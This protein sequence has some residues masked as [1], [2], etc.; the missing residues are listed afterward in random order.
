MKMTAD[1]R[2]MTIAYAD[3]LNIQEL[4]QH[5]LRIEADDLLRP[6]ARKA[7][8]LAAHCLDQV[9]TDVGLYVSAHTDFSSKDDAAS[10][11]TK[12]TA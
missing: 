7:F 1:E 8:A 2:K 9:M 3:M 10:E 4:V 11:E 6:E 12:R 5:I